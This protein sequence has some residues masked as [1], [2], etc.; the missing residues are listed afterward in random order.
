MA[1]NE[2][3][4]ALIAAFAPDDMSKASEVMRQQ[5]EYYIQRMGVN[6]YYSLEEPCIMAAIMILDKAYRANLTTDAIE[7]A[8][9]IADSIQLIT[10]R[11]AGDTDVQKADEN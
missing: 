4:T 9:Q 11:E 1:S 8:K 6:N 10:I 5:T 7:L 3:V 2:F